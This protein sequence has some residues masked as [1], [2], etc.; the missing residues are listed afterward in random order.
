ML[1]ATFASTLS[2]ALP[3]SNIEELRVNAT[4]AASFSLLNT[5]GVATVTVES[6]DSATTLTTDNIPV[7]TTAQ[8]WPTLAFRGDGTAAAQ[9]YDTVT[10]NAFGASAS[11][12]DKLTATFANRGAALN[13]TGTSN[14]HGISTL[15]V[16]SGSSTGI[17]QLTITA[18]DGPLT[19]GTSVSCNTCTTL[20]VSGSSN[21]ALGLVTAAADTITSV[22]ASGVVGNF[23]AVIDAMNGGTVLLGSG[24]DVLDLTGSAAAATTVQGGAGNDTLT[25]AGGVDSIQGGA[26]TDTIVG[27]AGAD[28][29]NGGDDADILQGDAGADTITTGNGADTV[30]LTTVAASSAN[31][32][33]VS[34]FTAG[35]GGDQLEMDLSALETSGATDSDEAVNFVELNDGSAV[36]ES[37]T[38]SIQEISSTAGA[39]TVTANVNALAII[40]TVATTGALETL[41]EAG[42]GAPLTIAA[43]AGDVTSCFPVLY[44]D[45]TDAYLAI[46]FA[47]TETANDTDFESGDLTCVN[48]AKMSSNAAISAS[49]F[50]AANL[51]FV[52]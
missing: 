1:Q 11:T 29:L 12:G 50:V 21:V 49:E 43:A 17:E 28:S 30:V 41:L 20:T 31:A 7:T 24:N 33:T 42:G 38:V 35:S 37:D 45:G 18:A 46:C 19:V 5:T 32:D 9:T 13:T 34:D 3:I 25:G 48:I 36:L 14:A 51:D 16:G 22:T 27:A 2:S 52:P 26:G 39:T 44:S 15:T 6:D 40:G 10:Y 47:E 23:T 4:S 8:T